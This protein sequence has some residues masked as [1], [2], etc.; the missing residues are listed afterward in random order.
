MVTY[1][2]QLSTS[3]IPICLMKESDSTEPGTILLPSGYIV[4]SWTSLL[5]EVKVFCKFFGIPMD[6]SSICKLQVWIFGGPDSSSRISGFCLLHTKCWSVIWSLPPELGEQCKS[7]C[8]NWQS[9]WCLFQCGTCYPEESK[10][11]FGGS[12]LHSHSNRSLHVSHHNT[13]CFEIFPKGNILSTISV[14]KEWRMG[15]KGKYSRYV[16][17]WAVSP[18]ASRMCII[19]LIQMVRICV[20]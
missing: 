18:A 4:N 17:K 14:K 5:S 3:L 19:A 10:F 16:S 9:S 6:T 12:R 20:S 7:Y 8:V 1:C 13:K 2:W 11:C 15:R